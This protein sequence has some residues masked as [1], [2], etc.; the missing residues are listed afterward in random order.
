M[1][2]MLL[3]WIATFGVYLTSYAQG[4]P[5]PI[6]NTL[7]IQAVQWSHNATYIAV[8][9]STNIAGYLEVINSVDN[10]V[11]YRLE[12]PTDGFTSVAWSPDDRFIAVGGYD[13]TIRIIDVPNRRDVITLWGHAATVT[14]VDWSPDGSLLA[15]S[16][17][18]DG[19]TLIWDTRS[20][21]QLYAL[22]R[23][24]L[25]PYSVRFDPQGQR[26]A[27][28]GE[29]GIRI[30]AVAN[31]NDPP[32]IYDLNVNVASFVWSQDGTQ[33]AFGTQEFPSIVSPSMP[34][35][36]QVYIINASSG[37]ILT[38]FQTGDLS[39]SGIDWTSDKRLLATHSENGM[40]R[41]WDAVSGTQIGSYMGTAS[42]PS[43]V[44]FSPLDGRMAFGIS[45][46]LSV[47]TPLDASL[48]DAPS[49]L[50]AEAI[51]IVVPDASA[52]RLQAI[53]NACQLQPVFEQQFQLQAT[54][55]NWTS[56]VTQVNALTDSQIPPACRA[57]LLA[58]A[59]ALQ[60]S[61]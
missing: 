46:P 35:S 38:R 57:D 10:R 36:S 17:S 2:Q 49:L 29:A 37:T 22:R 8:V 12:N 30:Y 31:L 47:V 33:I 53:L 25:F 14:G 5:S 3:I 59:A 43:N 50:S 20:Y 6:P 24:D 41:V 52:A 26:V 32:I 39:I 40:I 34:V 9:G 21:A 45:I 61:P 51:Q 27:V 13:Q 48:A 7:N 60:A 58:V 15:S 4:I 44:V 23:G 42:F 16:G 19:L 11:I 1:K 54:D 28:G 18:W 55:R 56:L